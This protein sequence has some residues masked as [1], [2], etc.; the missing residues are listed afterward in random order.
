VTTETESK[1][2]R[3][4][5]RLRDP[6]ILNDPEGTGEK[7]QY[8][9]ITSDMEGQVLAIKHRQ[10]ITATAKSIADE[11]GL[12]ER[13]VKYMLTELPHLRRQKDG[14]QVTAKSLKERIYDVISTVMV[15]RDV[16]EL[17]ELLGL[18]DTE[19][20]IV[21]VLHSLHTGGRIDFDERGNGQGTATYVNIRM[22]K[23]GR[24]PQVTTDALTEMA[25]LHTAVPA[26]EPEP[27]PVA[28]DTDQAP[29]QPAPVGEEY[30]LL[31]ALAEREW[32]RLDGD[33]KANS[34]L[35]AATAIEKIDPEMSRDL[36][37]KADALAEPFPS[38]V[39][40]EYLRFATAHLPQNQP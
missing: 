21:H 36:M 20:D 25:A 38:P 15:V 11:A 31:N 37:A 17:R 1:A 7:R 40:A 34:Y 3:R 23:R 26:G 14:D 18:G 12:P 39:E 24:K 32:R 28:Q 5:R 9:K 13:T 10:G 29:S 30:P 2:E 8:I 6:D 22:P 19:H 4:A 16:H 33:S 27:D 35:A